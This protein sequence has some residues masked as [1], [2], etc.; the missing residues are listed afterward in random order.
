MTYLYELQFAK[1]SLTY[2]EIIKEYEKSYAQSDVCTQ[3]LNNWNS[4]KEQ[5]VQ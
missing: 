3:I 4:L 5:K 1:H 2:W